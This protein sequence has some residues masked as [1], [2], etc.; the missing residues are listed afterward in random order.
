M[1]LAFWNLSTI[2]PRIC[3]NINNLLI[4]S[5]AL[6]FFL[7]HILFLGYGHERKFERIHFGS[8]FQRFHPFPLL[9]SWGERVNMAGSMLEQGNSLGGGKE[10]NRHYANTSKYFAFHILTH[11]GLSLLDSDIYILGGSFLLFSPL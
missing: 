3:K 4:F 2:Q 8:Q 6:Q 7:C 11:L 9:G 5:P 10:V 1:V